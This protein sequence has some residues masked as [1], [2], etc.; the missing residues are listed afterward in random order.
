MWARIKGQTEIALAKARLGGLVCWRPGVILG[1]R[2]SGRPPLSYRAIQA[3]FNVLAW[4]PW[5]TIDH[6]ALG[7]A[8]LQATLEGCREGTLE[9]REIRATAGRYR[10]AAGLVPVRADESSSVRLTRNG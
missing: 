8:M 10:A 2:P 3:V 4:M 6:V 7:Q 1:D 9:N 5:L